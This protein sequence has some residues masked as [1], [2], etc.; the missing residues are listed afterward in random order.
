MREQEPDHLSSASANALPGDIKDDRE[1]DDHEHR[2]DRYG[3]VDD[4]V[5]EQ[6]DEGDPGRRDRQDKQGQPGA[7]LGPDPEVRDVHPLTDPAAQLSRC[8]AGICSGSPAVT[9]PG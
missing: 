2:E 3:I 1:D 7:G 6:R 9:R 5:E 8:G 4:G